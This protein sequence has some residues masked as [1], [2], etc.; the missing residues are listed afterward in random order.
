MNATVID[1]TGSTCLIMFD[2]VLSKFLG[3]TASELL[4]ANDKVEFT[5]HNS[6]KQSCMVLKISFQFKINLLFFKL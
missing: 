2:G 4:G 6:L 3:K 1:E 5:Y